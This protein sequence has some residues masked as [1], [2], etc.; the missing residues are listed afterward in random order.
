MDIYYYIGIDVSKATLDWAVFDGKLIVLQ[1]Q[2][3]NSET[4][5]KAALKL[6]KALPGFC[7]KTSVSCCEHT[8]IY[9]ALILQ[10]LFGASFPVWL[11]SSLQIKQAGGLQRGKS[12]QIDA[13]RIAE[14]AF[15]FRDRLRLW[16]PPRQLLQDLTSL[17]ALRQRL[18]LVRSQLQ[19]PIN[20]Q[21]GFS[22]PKRQKQLV[23]NCQAS[24]KAINADL[25]NVDQQITQLIQ[26][27]DQLKELFALMTSIP[28]IGMATAT[29]V[30]LA[31]D[32]FNAITDPKK[33]AC[34]AG[35]APFEYRSGTSI[36][37]KTRVSQHARKRLK[38]LFHL[39]AMSA[40]RAKGELQDYYRRKVAEGKNKM[41][42]LNAIRNK[43]IH[44][45]YAVIRRGEKYDKFYRYTLA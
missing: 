26:D 18:L 2:S 35:V 34:H 33:L 20:E 42:V 6:I 36:R 29:E 28:G 41:L 16:Q 3:P 37:G 19:Q 17:S 27:D 9:N 23:K 24:L 13:Q 21:A 30:I 4:G 31:T 32:E 15:R 45:I 43:L 1:I 25:E 8:G 22:D 11:E 38:S 7:P 5:I 14:Y 40:I 10:Q 44:R 12:D 39:A